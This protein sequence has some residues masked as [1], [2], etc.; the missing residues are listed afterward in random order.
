MGADTVALTGGEPTL[1]PR[2][3]AVVDL[4]V[5]SGLGFRLVTNGGAG[6]RRIL[7]AILN[8]GRRSALQRVVF[9]L[10]GPTA[11]VHDRLRGRGSFRSVMG[12]IA[13]CRARGVPFG[14]Q[15]TL[16]ARNRRRLDA[17]ALLASHLGAEVI[18]L[19]HVQP[20]PDNVARGIALPLTEWRGVE[21]DVARLA[22][23]IKTPV[24]PCHGVFNPDPLATCAA[25]RGESLHVDAA[26][27]LIFCCGLSW[28]PAASGGRRDGVVLADL[29][30]VTLA[31]GYRRLLA[32]ARRLA[33][34]RLRRL[35]KDPSGAD[36][37]IGFP[38]LSCHRHFGHMEWTDAW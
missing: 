35:L 18:G 34:W 23:T 31:D 19:D 17:I 2:F 11:A 32:R 24:A 14:V 4:L 37:R 25:M 20:T 9:S 27:R 30:A 26:G 33:E 7:P 15:V 36:P 1:H 21:R 22:K 13:I 29:S 28:Y 10:D 6:F 12:S 38:C 5:R 8:A 3:V 16:G